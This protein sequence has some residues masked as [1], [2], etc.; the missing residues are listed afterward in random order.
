MKYVNEAK[1]QFEIA[2]QRLQLFVSNLKKAEHALEQCKKKLTD[3]SYAEK[4]V[5]DE[6]NSLRESLPV[7]DKKTVSV[8]SR[9][10]HYILLC[11]VIF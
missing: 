10:V 7:I 3:V 8:S 5:V 6:L 9:C 11:S 4:G 1:G 2:D